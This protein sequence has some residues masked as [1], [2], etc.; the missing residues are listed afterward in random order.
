MHSSHSVDL[1][2][3]FA[4]LADAQ[5]ITH[6]NRIG[7]GH[8]RHRLLTSLLVT[9]MQDHGMSWLDQELGGHSTKPVGRSSNENACHV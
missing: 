6:N 1:I 3:D 7:P 9:C 8:S 4:Y 2:G 5:E